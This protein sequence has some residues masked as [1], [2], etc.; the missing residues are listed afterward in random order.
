MSRPFLVPVTL[1]LC[2]AALTA[3]GCGDHAEPEEDPNAEAC[4]HIQDA[5]NAVAVTTAAT[6]SDSAPEVKADHKRYDVALQTVDDRN[7]EGYVRYASTEAG[8]ALLFTDQ[9]THISMQTAAGDQLSAE[10]TDGAIPACTQVKHRSV[11]ALG[12]G[13]HLI[14]FWY[15]SAP[16]IGLVIETHHH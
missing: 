13:T 5:A 14:R 6:A 8:D 12:V 3:S 15:T 2:T 10:S 16:K 7:Y 1:A 4:K 11:F 9:V